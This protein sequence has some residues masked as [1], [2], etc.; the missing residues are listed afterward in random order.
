MSR[1]K[2]FNGT[3]LGSSKN[4]NENFKDFTNIY[5]KRI[6][7]FSVAIFRVMENVKLLEKNES[8]T[9]MENHNKK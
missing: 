8:L 7:L 9:E 5:I 1:Q 4:K 3:I 6:F 2:F